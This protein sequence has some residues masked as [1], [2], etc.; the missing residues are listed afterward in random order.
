MHNNNHLEYRLEKLLTQIVCSNDLHAKWVNA[1]SYLENCGARKI[2]KN[3]DPIMVNEEMLKHAAEEFRHAY[4]LK[5][6]IYKITDKRYE[7]YSVESILG[8]YSTFHYLDK[9][10]LKICRFLTKDYKFPR[11]FLK[12]TAYLLVTYAIE[13]RA[14][15]LYP[16]YQKVLTTQSSQ[17]SMRFIIAE[18]DQHLNDISNLLSLFDNNDLMKSKACAIE[19]NLFNTLFK[20][21]DQ[22]V[23]NIKFRNS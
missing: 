17:I 20:K 16:L 21:I 10:E 3:E 11:H 13:M 15:F 2:A 23:K 19:E 6:Q 1:L 9:L 5:K 14:S 8:E 4:Y 12:H 7:N 22:T 18:E